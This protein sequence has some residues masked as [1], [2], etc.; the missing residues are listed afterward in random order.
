VLL[1]VRIYGNSLG[2]Q[3]FNYNF[4]GTTGSRSNITSRVY[5]GGSAPGATSGSVQNGFGMITRFT[6]R[7][8]VVLN[9]GTGCAG[10]GGF[11]PEASVSG[12]AWP[13]IT[14]THTLSNAASGRTCVFGFGL[15]NTNI[16][17]TPLPADLTQLLGFGPSGCLLRTSADVQVYATTVGG[18][19]GGGFCT[20]PV[21]LPA[22]TGYVGSSVFTQWA[23]LD[24]FASNGVLSTTAMTWTI[25]APVGG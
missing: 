13:G 18:G 15:D 7:P 20:I 25:V 3:P 4:R 2:S 19:P 23:V 12:L 22:T 10:E 8:G 16:G 1:E 17:G 24:P 21:P 14:W 11:V 5:A 6:A 9:V